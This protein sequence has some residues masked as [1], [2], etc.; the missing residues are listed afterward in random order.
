MSKA[1]RD[2]LEE[3]RRAQEIADMRRKLNSGEM[4]RVQNTDYCLSREDYKQLVS[5]LAS[6]NLALSGPKD[7]PKDVMLHY[8]TDRYAITV[9]PLQQKQ[10]QPSKKGWYHEEQSRVVAASPSRR[11]F[12]LN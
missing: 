8:P 5:D 11:E 6:Q 9:V 1:K 3:A 10:E 2:F 12:Q 4:V 7:S